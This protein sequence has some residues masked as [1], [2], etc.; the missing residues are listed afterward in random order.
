MIQIL[1]ETEYFLCNRIA[2]YNLNAREKIWWRE[3]PP[4]VL[5]LV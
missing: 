1:K 2:K 3:E 4:K 5:F